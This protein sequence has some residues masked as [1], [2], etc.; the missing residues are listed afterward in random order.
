[1]V[2]SFNSNNFYFDKSVYL[3]DKNNR[4]NKN[5]TNLSYDDIE[6]KDPNE[7]SFKFYDR[8]DTYKGLFNTQ[9]LIGA[10]NFDNFENHC[11]FDSAISKTEYA[12]NTIYD[13]FPIDGKKEEIDEFFSNIDGFTKSIYNKFDKNIG[14]LKFDNSYVSVQNESGY[15]FS[16]SRNEEIT[17]KISTKILNPKNSNFAIDFRFSVIDSNIENQVIYQYLDNS[18]GKYN[19]FT[20]FLKNIFVANNKKFA[21]IVFL[22]TAEGLIKNY[23]YCKFFVPIEEWQHL[24]ISVENISNSK[25]SINVILNEENLLFERITNIKNF[26]IENLKNYIFENFDSNVSVNIGDSFNFLIGKGL[27]SHVGTG[28]FSLTSKNNF[29]GYID[30]FRFYHSSLDRNFSIKNKEKN[31][32]AT[33]SLKLYFRFNE[34]AGSHINNS[35]VFDH[36]GNSLHSWINLNSDI[37]VGKTQQQIREIIS[38]YRLKTI[39]NSSLRFEESD[40]NPVLLPTF[41]N[42]IDLNNQ[43]IQEAKNYDLYNPNLVF[44]LIPKHYLLQGS[45]LDKSDEIYRNQTGQSYY[46]ANSQNNFPGQQ[47]TEAAQ[48]FINLLLIWSRFFDQLKLYLQILPEMID[49]DYNDISKSSNVNFF[50]PL[51]AKLRGFDFKEILNSPT[52]KILDGYILGADGEDKSQYTLRY[53][54]N[55]IWKRILINSNDMISS[56]GTIHSLRSIFNSV[57][58]PPDEYYRFREFGTQSYNFID[59]NTENIVKNIQYL[60]FKNILPEDSEVYSEIVDYPSF[61]YHEYKINSN[62]LFVFNQYFDFYE[63]NINCLAMEFLLN[64]D[65]SASKNQNILIESILKFEEIDPAGNFPTQIELIFIKSSVYSTKGNIY[66]FLKDYNSLNLLNPSDYQNY[67]C[68][69]DIDLLDNSNWHFSLQFL[70]G[71]SKNK[72][73][74]NVNRAGNVFSQNESYLLELDI[75]IEDDLIFFNSINRPLKMMFGSRSSRLIN[76]KRL[77]SSFYHNE[78]QNLNQNPYISKFSDLLIDSEY[79]FKKFIN[80]NGNI[81]FIKQWKLS[82][83]LQKN[84]VIEHIRNPYSLSCEELI[85]SKK[86]NKKIKDFLILDLNAQ[87]DFK[88]SIDFSYSFL[89]NLKFSTV[90]IIDF[91]QNTNIDENFENYKSNISFDFIKYNNDT[92]SIAN[93]VLTKNIY[94]KRFDSK[95]DEINMSN[96]VDV[97]GYLDIK[98]AEIESKEIAPVHNSKGFINKKRSDSRFSIEMSN[99]KHLNE[100]IS[101]LFSGMDYFSNILSN[102]SNINDNFYPDFEKLQ[103]TYFE[104]MTIENPN[105]TPLYEIYQIFDNIL[106]DLLSQFVPSRV[107]FY[108]NVYTIESHSLERHKFYYKQHECNSPII[109]NIEAISPYNS[110]RNLNYLNKQGRILRE[111]D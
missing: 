1:M 57:G 31:V 6:K 94:L 86:Q 41:Q 11:F 64:Y 35:L 48:T 109:G 10:I 89:N 40:L 73:K 36:S 76:N 72:I 77:G 53:I 88:N 93:N 2:N 106:T 19:G 50:I 104:R 61:Q 56:K 65:V 33:E 99:V 102:N 17:N 34:P 100:D 83:E 85:F 67:P 110:K 18:S 47:K 71:N 69:K 21:N 16:M 29:K 87:Q 105:I 25:K 7:Y 28:Y 44:K 4:T 95:F 79:L 42:H 32:Y 98:T 74:L 15:V 24:I 70:K 51:M 81:S 37:L 62:C 23:S 52:N 78:L 80:F 55:E 46:D 84:D 14:Y 97:A 107:K 8:F 43:Y 5:N 66:I 101:L 13:K 59:N 92:S 91:S 27:Y 45:D 75:P 82:K 20:L 63:E 90:K 9:Q 108:N 38:S 60:Q 12:F 22:L 30:E 68:I 54:Q 103:R 111:Y 26:T 96:K 39:G 58:I 49:L 3:K